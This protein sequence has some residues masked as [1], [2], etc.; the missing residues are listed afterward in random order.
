MKKYY[1][2]GTLETPV[3]FAVLGDTPADA[4]ERVEKGTYI[5]MRDTSKPELNKESLNITKVQD[6]PLEPCPFCGSPA[7]AVWIHNESRDWV[8]IQC[9]DKYCRRRVDCYS[10]DFDLETAAN[11]WNVRKRK[12]VQQ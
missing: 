8:R 9:S 2:E 6:V 3:I 11:R 10:S 7:E 12:G 4:L 1:I 5:E